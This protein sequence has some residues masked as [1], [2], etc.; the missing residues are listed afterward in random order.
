M[1][2]VRYPDGVKQLLE[3]ARVIAVLGAHP[4]RT[5]A[6]FYVPDYLVQQGYRILPVNPT[7]VGEILWG[8]PVRASLTDIDE[9]VDVVDVFRRSAAL[10]GHLDEIRSMKPLPQW[11][12][13]QQGI[14]DDTFAAHLM[15]VGIAV[16]QDRCM[17]A[18][19]RRLKTG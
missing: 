8:E 9:P 17:L 3:H 12:W 13:L 2:E 11:V 16:V 10:M 7:R 5:R 15:D 1:P 6:A 19:H 14:R 4:Q 18:D